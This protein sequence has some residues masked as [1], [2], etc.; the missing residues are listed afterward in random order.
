[1]PLDP[2]FVADAPYSPEG[3][4]LDEILLVDPANQLV[5]A[6]MPT[7]E[8]LPSPMRNG[9]IRFATRATSLAG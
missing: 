9:P 3:L 8:N 1:M 7:S 5:R 4:L 6:R 2:E